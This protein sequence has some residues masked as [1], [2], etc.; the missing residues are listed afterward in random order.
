MNEKETIDEIVDD[1]FELIEDKSVSTKMVS[2]NG[3]STFFVNGKEVSKE[4]YLEASKKI[5]IHNDLP[6]SKLDYLLDKFDKQ[7]FP[8][9]RP[10]RKLPLFDVYY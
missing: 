9:M 1:I 7:Y 8:T 2:I 5:Q 6:E 10:V 4:E 3:K